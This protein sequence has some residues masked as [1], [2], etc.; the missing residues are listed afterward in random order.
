MD[1]SAG[2]VNNRA[3]CGYSWIIIVR[4]RTKPYYLR[5]KRVP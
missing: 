1:Y 4:N 2:G 5:A 3:I